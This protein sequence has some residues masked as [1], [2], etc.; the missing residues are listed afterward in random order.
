[1]Y[2]IVKK[3]TN[4]DH[5]YCIVLLSSKSEKKNLHVYEIIFGEHQAPK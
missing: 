5:L 1:M 3:L 2:D 4:T